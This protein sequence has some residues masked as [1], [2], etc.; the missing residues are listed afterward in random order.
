MERHAWM[1]PLID[2]LYRAIGRPREPRPNLLYWYR[3]SA[4]FIVTVSKSTYTLTVDAV[5]ATERARIARRYGIAFPR[6]YPI[7]IGANPDG[8]DKQAVGDKRTPEGAFRV[9]QKLRLSRPHG[10]YGGHW[11]R[12]DTRAAGWD[13]IGIHGTNKP[14]TIGTRATAGCVR[15]H[16]ADVAELYRL[17]PLG[18]LVRIIP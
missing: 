17:L 11:L 4:R 5:S 18:T 14:Q 16:N 13:G 2:L 12:L 8:A 1:R 7:A 6:S 15:L 9:C 3:P 10:G